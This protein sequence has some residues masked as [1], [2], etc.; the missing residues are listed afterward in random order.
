VELA[1][2]TSSEYL[3]LHPDTTAFVSSLY[4]DILNRAPSA[5]EVLPWVSIAGGP[6]G[7]ARVALGILTSVEAYRDLISEEY[8]SV[9]GRAPDL[10]GLDGWVGALVNGQISRDEVA[11]LFLSSDEAYERS[12]L[13]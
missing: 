10:L 13:Q 2:M 8:V 11:G 3:Q 9:L 1:F 7:L 6:L 5:A 4:E 12:L